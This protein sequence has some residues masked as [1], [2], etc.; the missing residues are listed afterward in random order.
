MALVKFGGGVTGMAG[1]IGGTTFARN[2]YGAYAR[3]RTKPV[4][5][6][7]PMQTKIRALMSQI[8]EIWFTVLDADERAAWTLYAANVLMKNRLG[9]SQAFTGF[10][11]FV[12]SA[13]A[14]MY[15][16][17]VAIHPGPAV[18]SLAEQDDSITAAG[19]ADDQKIGVGFDD[20]LAWCTEV[21]AY[22]LLYAGA[23]QDITRNFFGGPWKLLGKVAGAAIKP[24]TP[25]SLD[26]PYTIADGQ[27]IWIKGRIVRA[28]GRLSEFFRCDGLVAAS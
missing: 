28:D 10:N 23:P 22:M 2:R 6:K 27:K 14:L 9:E 19:T 20:T 1:S 26:S 24:T 5:A 15:N 4:N 25:A 21:G 18:F 8:R 3:A 11:H 12:R 17:L 13:A 16:D 7:T